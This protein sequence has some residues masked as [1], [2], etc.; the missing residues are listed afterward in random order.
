MTIFYGRTTHGTSIQI[1]LPPNF[2][3]D[4]QLQFSAPVEGTS[5]SKQFTQEDGI[6]KRKNKHH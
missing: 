1:E 2:R 6:E 3:S 5:G 4:S